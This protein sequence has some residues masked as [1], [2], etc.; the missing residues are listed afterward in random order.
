MTYELR[1]KSKVEELTSNRDWGTPETDVEPRRVNIPAD[2]SDEDLLPMPT[3]DPDQ[4]PDQDPDPKPESEP[5][6]TAPDPDP[7]PEPES[8]VDRLKRE[9]EGR[10]RALVA[11]RQRA[12]AVGQQ[13]ASLKDD[14]EKLRVDLTA[15]PPA[16]KP[17]KD[18]APVDYL[19]ATFNEKLDEI[20]QRV[21]QLTGSIEADRSREDVVQV[22]QATA[23]YENQFAQ[24]HPDYNEAFQH[25][26]ARY[27]EDFASKLIANGEDPYQA[28]T[29]AEALALDY[30]YRL[31]KDL[32]LK[33]QDPAAAF[34][35]EAQRLGYAP[36]AAAAPTGAPN[37]KAQRGAARTSLS[38]PGF[39]GTSKHPTKNTGTVSRDWVFENLNK[40]QRTKIWSNPEL[41]RQMDD[42]G[43]V[44]L[45]ENFF[46]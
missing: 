4:D 11:E 9:S 12:S 42:T 36:T 44:T 29:K 13:F 41:N 32:L 19:E 16:P 43:E 35:A 37:P 31:S 25:V 7:K 45:P 3:S 15:K 1:N 33:G 18:E 10:L 8:E 23:W 21:G 26:A 40:A 34:Y 17:D 2:G 30:G 39:S 6:T 22:G 27:I 5:D 20:N 24:K 46:D 28:R 38:Q 14:L